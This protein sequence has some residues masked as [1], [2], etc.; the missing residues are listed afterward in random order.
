MAKED[1]D[2]Q[3]SGTAYE[4]ILK[5]LPTNQSTGSESTGSAYDNIAPATKEK[6]EPTA[7][8][9]ISSPIIDQVL[10][11]VVGAGT[12][13]ALSKYGTQPY[14]LTPEFK[15]AKTALSDADIAKNSI[16][17]NLNNINAAHAGSVGQLEIAYAD[18]LSQL[19][20]LEQQ[21]NEA[22]HRAEMLDALDF[23]E[24]KVPGA[25]GTY[26]YTAVMPGDEIPH[27]MI[28]QAED[29]TTGQH[30]KGAGDIAE[31]NRLLAEKQR[32]LG[33]GDYRLKGNLE[34]QLFVPPQKGITPGEQRR[35]KK[36]YD[37]AK[38][39]H[40]E[41]VAETKKL[42]DQL[43]KLKVS[44]PEGYSNAAKALSNIEI[45]YLKA[46]GKLEDLIPKPGR[47]AQALN[48]I[49]GVEPTL[50]AL[51][52][53]NQ[54]I[55]RTPV[56]KRV[57]PAGMGALS[58]VQALEGLEDWNKG[59][60]VKGGLEMLSGVGGMIGTMPHP[61]ARGIGLASQLPYLGYEGY[62]YL[63]DKLKSKKP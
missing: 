26:N 29:M 34:N 21:L 63:A 4:D 53:A 43:E 50:G 12:G 56:V 42:A 8:V 52:A 14:E 20:T 35:A 16:Q 59:E 10:P 15:T 51:S 30:G 54:W 25:S 41:Y 45:D 22:K 48:R 57:V 38:S 3:F 58:S 47:I 46:Q 31:K 5:N 39:A 49:P 27:K 55:N 9:E 60:K 24:R 32:A 33:Y 44:K 11:A 1:K 13:L 36:A 61:I 2:S 62:E 19:K 37:I 17:S 40:S 6:K 23:G 18:R 28:I 7:S